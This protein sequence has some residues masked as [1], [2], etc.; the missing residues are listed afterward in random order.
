MNKLL[1]AFGLSLL[2][3]TMAS[4]TA[5]Q[6]INVQS[7][8]IDADRDWQVKIDFNYFRD[9]VDFGYLSRN[10]FSTSS[11]EL[12][13]IDVRRNIETKIPLRIG[14]NTALA[15]GSMR[16]ET[17]MYSPG[18]A[19]RGTYDVESGHFG[20]GNLGLTLEAAFINTE[21]FAVTGYINQ[22]FALAHDASMVA[23]ALRLTSG[24]KAYG[25]QTGF[26]ISKKLAGGFSNHAN[27]GYRFDVPESGH[28]QNSFIYWDELVWDTDTFINPSLAI[29]GTSVYSNNIGTDLRIVPGWVNS[30]GEDDQYQLRFG[31]PIGLTSDSTDFGV[32]VGLFAAI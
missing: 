25:F 31:F 3:P 8:Y 27:L 12:P 13:R 11:M 21:D 28:L 5:I 2:I 22:H 1:Y 26:E 30:F 9:N 19:Y 15:L 6:P 23:N 17:V 4:A 7:A 20:F 16:T 32:Q 29:L 14:L 18:G 10:H 24:S